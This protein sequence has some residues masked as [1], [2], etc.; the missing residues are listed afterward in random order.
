MTGGCTTIGMCMH[1]YIVL[2]RIFTGID[3]DIGNGIVGYHHGRSPWVPVHL[4][5]IL[6][7]APSSANAL[8][9]SNTPRPKAS[10]FIDTDDTD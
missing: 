2:L 4:G 9:G 5:M 3:N 6:Q 10:D 7:H 1:V 8:T